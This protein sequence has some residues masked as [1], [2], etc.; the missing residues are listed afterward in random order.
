MDFDLFK[1]VQENQERISMFF[2]ILGILICI[3]TILFCSKYPPTN[4]ENL[5]I[6]IRLVVAFFSMWILGFMIECHRLDNLLI[7]NDPKKIN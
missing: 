6:I 3:A 2:F 5:W 4:Y 1:V 7:K